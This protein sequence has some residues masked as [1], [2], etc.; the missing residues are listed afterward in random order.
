MN[1]SQTRNTAMVLIQ[2][3]ALE[4]VII[5]M[6][7]QGK[8][9]SRLVIAMKNLTDKILFPYNSFEQVDTHTFSQRI[10]LERDKI[11]RFGK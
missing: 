3:R 1:E 7:E 10:E 11:R 4:S 5:E 2:I 9:T 8:D 6:A